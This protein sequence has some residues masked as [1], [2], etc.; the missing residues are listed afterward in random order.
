V[1]HG[2]HP[3][4]FKAVIQEVRLFLPGAIEPAF[5]RGSL[6]AVKKFRG[7]SFRLGIQGEK[8]YIKEAFPKLQF[9][10]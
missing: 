6:G 5:R 7:P 4:N 8:G 10:G 3:D 2:V 9:L 1:G